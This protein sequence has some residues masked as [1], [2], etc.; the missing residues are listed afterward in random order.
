MES[1]QSQAWVPTPSKQHFHG[2][3]ASDWETHYELQPG[4]VVGVSPHMMVRIGYGV[5]IV[6]FLI[7]QFFFNIA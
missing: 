3:C 4:D 2:G 5:G 7:L 1:F 6:M